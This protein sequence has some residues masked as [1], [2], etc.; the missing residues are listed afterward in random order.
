M[1][2]DYCSTPP[3]NNGMQRTRNQ[4]AFHHQS[5]VRAADAGRSAHYFC[6][7]KSYEASFLYIPFG[8]AFHSAG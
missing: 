4:R 3:P 1:K 5:S 6:E 2:V 7:R 8:A